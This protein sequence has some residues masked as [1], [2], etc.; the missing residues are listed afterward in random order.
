LAAAFTLEGELGDIWTLQRTQIYRALE[1]LERDGLVKPVRL[2]VGD[3]GPARTV[4]SITQ[5]GRQEVERWL[6]TPVDRLRYGRSDLRLKLAF[7]T[8]S[9]RNPERFL[10]LQRGVFQAILASLEAKLPLAE[11]VS[12]MSL[13]WR[14]EM[15]RGSLR[16]VETLLTERW[17]AGRL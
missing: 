8:R 3:A 7:W 15:A 6:F 16:F 5:E 1:H 11:G 9:N 12:R 4:Y 14:L 2:E 13:L 17:S 10:E